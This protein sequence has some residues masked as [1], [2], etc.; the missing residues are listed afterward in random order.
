MS[1][2]VTRVKIITDDMA[3]TSV[4]RGHCVA[5]HINHATINAQ[6][7][8]IVDCA[9]QS[10]TNFSDYVSGVNAVCVQRYVDQAMEARLLRLRQNGIRI[11]FD[12]DDAVWLL[13]ASAKEDTHGYQ[14]YCT[15]ELR[16]RYKRVLPMFDAV[17]CSTPELADAIV[18][19]CPAVN[20]RVTTILNSIEPSFFYPDMER[21]RDDGAINVAWYGCI[22]HAANAH[23]A[24]DVLTGILDEIPGSVVHLRG[25]ANKFT[26][27]EPAI[28]KH[29][30]R[31]KL[32]AACYYTELGEWLR[33]MDVGLCPLIDTPFTRCK[34]EIKMLEFQACGV[35]VIASV[36]APY[37][38]AQRDLIFQVFRQ[39][40][41]MQNTASE[42][43]RCVKAFVA[44]PELDKREMHATTVSAY[45]IATVLDKW[46]SVLTGA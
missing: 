9:H 1:Q 12:I 33:G 26:G 43:V 18:E 36:V 40:C 32:N 29:G 34:S 28:K 44:V 17:I 13:P 35:P 25:P 37:V 27:I 39:N 11:V 30:P 22:S 23:F 4:I 31:V 3:A 8:I 10:H 20:G 14:C 2:S 41:T 15:D 6:N 5:A 16:E 7:R 19:F 38:R 46:M 45:G 42:W 21:K 24:G